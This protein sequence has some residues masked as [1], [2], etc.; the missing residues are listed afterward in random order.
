MW[1]AS[2]SAAATVLRSI[3]TL[4]LEVRLTW[5]KGGLVASTRRSAHSRMVWT[6]LATAK[7]Q[8]MTTVTTMTRNQLLLRRPT[9][10]SHKKW[11]QRL[12]NWLHPNSLLRHSQIGEMFWVG[13]IL[14][15]M[16]CGTESRNNKWRILSGWAARNWDS[17][18][19]SVLLRTLLTTTGWQTRTG[20]FFIVLPA[21]HIPR[22]PNPHEG[23]RESVMYSM[24]NY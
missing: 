9:Q 6:L 3:A 15:M 7:I 2:I 17:V 14:P 8:K 13:Q 21:S 1:I 16:V 20:L 11:R 22:N 5:Q 24:R 19:Q 10:T 23:W 12:Q 18:M 4:L